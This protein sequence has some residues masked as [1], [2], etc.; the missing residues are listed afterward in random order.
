MYIYTYIYNA[1]WS[2]TMGNLMCI[3][4][5]VALSFPYMCCENSF[6][7]IRNYDKDEYICATNSASG[8][9]WLGSRQD[10]NGEHLYWS[11]FSRIPF[12][13]IFIQYE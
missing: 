12:R 9:S 13:Y 1:R 10:Q 8:L 6:F 4:Y 7:L 5:F 11:D 2:G 3:V